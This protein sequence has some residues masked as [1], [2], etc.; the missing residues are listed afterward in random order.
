MERA[1]VGITES[2]MVIIHFRFFKSCNLQSNSLTYF[3]IIT[4]SVREYI[5][6]RE[7]EENRNYID[8]KGMR[9]NNYAIQYMK[10]LF[11]DVI[12]LF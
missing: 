2:V 8:K 7:N 10:W 5:I 11:S 4:F 12:K 6:E 1:D 9:N 3:L